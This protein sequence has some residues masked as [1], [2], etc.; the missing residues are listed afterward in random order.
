M[1]PERATEREDPDEHED[2]H[3]DEPR[4]PVRVFEGGDALARQRGF[5]ARW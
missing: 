2:E 3:G 4:G 1:G 5:T